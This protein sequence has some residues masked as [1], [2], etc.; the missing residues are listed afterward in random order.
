M[1]LLATATPPLPVTKR[2]YIFMEDR[3]SNNLLNFVFV[4]SASNYQGI[5]VLRVPGITRTLCAACWPSWVESDSIPRSLYGR[6]PP[7]AAGPL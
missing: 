6:K 2:T 4:P 5:T 3:H 7:W 1:A